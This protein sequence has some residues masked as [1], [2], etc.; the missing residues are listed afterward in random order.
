MAGRHSKSFFDFRKNVHPIPL[1]NNK[2]GE[3]TILLPYKII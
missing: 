3:D 1:N 2:S